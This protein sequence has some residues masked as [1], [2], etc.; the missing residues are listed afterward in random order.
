MWLCFDPAFLVSSCHHAL[1]L[2]ALVGG[3][4]APGFLDTHSF[5]HKPG[6]IHVFHRLEQAAPFLRPV[7]SDAS[8]LVQYSIWISARRIDIPT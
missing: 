6:A 1:S 4:Y 8:K 7:A 2:S 3:D 5:S